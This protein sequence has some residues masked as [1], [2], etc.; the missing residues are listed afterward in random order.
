MLEDI[1]TLTNGQMI[2]EG[3]GIKLETW[4]SPCSSKAKRNVLELDARTL[5]D[6][7]AIGQR[8]DVLQH[9]F[10]PVVAPKPSTQLGGGVGGGARS[11]R[12]FTTASVEPSISGTFQNLT[13]YL[14]ACANVMQRVRHLTL[15]NQSPSAA[16]A[17][18]LGCRAGNRSPSK[19]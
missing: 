5:G 15:L 18:S 7:L 8:G 12:S 17:G 10:A 19:G 16:L 3:L 6:H 13:R 11:D 14:E 2:S 9:G 1:A 4:R